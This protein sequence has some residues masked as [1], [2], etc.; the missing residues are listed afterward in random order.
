MK[1]E[2]DGSIPAT[3]EMLKIG[4]IAT[5]LATIEANQ[6]A[7]LQGEAIILHFLTNKD[8]SEQFWHDK[9]GEIVAREMPKVLADVSESLARLAA[10]LESRRQRR[11]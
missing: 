7:I 1:S 9:L 10:T 11:N 3:D 8:K 6:R 2:P 5:H 4:C